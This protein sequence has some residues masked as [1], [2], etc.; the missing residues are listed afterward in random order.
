MVP[1]DLMTEACTCF[2][3]RMQV[4]RGK[5]DGRSAGEI[6]TGNEGLGFCLAESSIK[7]VLLLVGNNKT[8][9]PMQSWIVLQ[10]P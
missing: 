10:K 3:V 6:N 9:L 4:G 5:G 2:V 1:E 8:D 7:K